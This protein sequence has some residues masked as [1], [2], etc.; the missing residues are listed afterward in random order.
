MRRAVQRVKALFAELVEI[1]KA[2]HALRTLEFR[3][4]ILAECEFYIAAL[5]N[6]DRS[7]KRRRHVREEA[8]KLLFALE[9]E[10]LRLKLH[11]VWVIDGLALSLIHI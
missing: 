2:R 11:A 8:A 4:E 9:I 6:P 1:R 7:L 5:C 3:Q 10:F